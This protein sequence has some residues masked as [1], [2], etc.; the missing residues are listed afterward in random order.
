MARRSRN[1]N[2]PPARAARP[3]SRPACRLLS[4]GVIRG[5]TSTG[6]VRIRSICLLNGLKKHPESWYANL[7]TGQFS[8][9]A[10]RGELNKSG[11]W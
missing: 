3:A 10:V 2:W 8:D 7:H 5:S 4:N 6:S 1:P 11:R 9:G